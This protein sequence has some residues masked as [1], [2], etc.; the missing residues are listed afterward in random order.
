[1]KGEIIEVKGHIEVTFYKSSFKSQER[2]TKEV[3][4]FKNLAI[5]PYMK[6]KINIV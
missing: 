1:M 2:L 6:V 5:Y 3:E 4:K